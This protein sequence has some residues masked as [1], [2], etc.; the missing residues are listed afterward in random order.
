ISAGAGMAG[1]AFCGATGG[2]GCV[3]IAAGVIGMV[4]GGASNIGAAKLMGEKYGA[5]DVASW[6]LGSAGFG[7]GAVKG[8][9]SY[10]GIGGWDLTKMAVRRASMGEFRTTFGLAW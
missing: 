9:R 5:G 4:A 1:A 8:V 3:V 2:L 10:L 7:G 6:T